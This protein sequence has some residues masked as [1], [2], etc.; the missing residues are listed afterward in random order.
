METDSGNYLNV[1]LKNKIIQNASI[2]DYLKKYKYKINKDLHNKIKTDLKGRSFKVSYAKRNYQIDDIL[3]DKTPQNTTINYEGETINLIQYYEKVHD[4]KIKDKNQ[5]LILVRKANSQ[6]EPICLHFIPELCSLSGIEDSSAK[7]GYFM[8]ELAKYTKL[9]PIDRVK[10][11]NEFLNLLSDKEK[12]PQHP[13]RM[14]SKE[15]CES[16]GI[17]IEPVNKLFEAYY[18]KETKLIGGN[19]Q[20]VYPTDRTFSVLKKKI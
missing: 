9:E 4:L 3:F 13:D 8:K 6:G 10:K 1:T 12:D 5:P 17:E 18:M 16:Y 7:D 19:K 14:S 15:K 2:Y 11:T 20:E